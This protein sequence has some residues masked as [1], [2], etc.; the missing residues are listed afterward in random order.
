MRKTLSVLLCGAT[1][2]IVAPNPWSSTSPTWSQ[3]ELRCRSMRPTL[4]AHGRPLA[5]DRGYA[6]CRREAA[7]RSAAEGAVFG[8]P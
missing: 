7:A 3:P 6:A 2:A 8:Q 5:D 1:V 4:T